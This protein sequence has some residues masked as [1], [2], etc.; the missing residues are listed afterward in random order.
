MYLL[1]SL[2]LSY[3]LLIMYFASAYLLTMHA[4]DIHLYVIFST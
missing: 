1:N 2:Y 4:T 3:G